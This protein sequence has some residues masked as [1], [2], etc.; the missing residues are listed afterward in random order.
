MSITLSQKLVTTCTAITGGIDP[1]DGIGEFYQFNLTGAA[2]IQTGDGYSIIVTDLTSGSQTLLGYGTV[3]GITPTFAFTFN[4]KEYVLAKDTVYFSSID[5][6]AS[7]NSL[8]GIGNSYVQLSD[9]NGQSTNLI[10]VAEFQGNLAFFSQNCIQIWQTNADPLQWDLVQTIQNSGTIAAN[11][12]QPMG[13]LDVLYLHY[14]GVRSLRA[15]EITGFSFVNDLGS[16]IDSLIQA[17]LIANGINSAAGACSIVDPTTGRYWLYL[18]GLIYIFSYFP[19]IKILSWSTYTP[20][21]FSPL[22]PATTGGSVVSFN[23]VPGHTYAWV[24][25]NATSVGEGG[26]NWY[27]SQNIVAPT[28]Q[29]YITYPGTPDESSTLTDLTQALTIVP[30]GFEIYNGQVYINTANGIY[31]YGGANN[32]TYDATQATA[33][34]AFLDF[35]HPGT[36]KAAESL[37]CDVSGGWNLYVGMVGPGQPMQ[38]GQL[39]DVMQLVF[40]TNIPSYQLQS[41]VCTNMEGYQVR[42]MAQTTGSTAAVLGALTFHYRMENEKD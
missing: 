25:G 36:L 20:T 40:T 41:Q 2:T 24:K 5:D 28:F 15:R 37:D 31:I 1:L 21:I 35:K 32:N 16:A 26:V 29:L 12:V 3:T 17:S 33:A 39:N 30:T 13:D 11:S 14:T 6:A 4:K 42:F 27:T 22:T 8:T 9:V 18:N 38:T 19:T 23:T 7:W 34:T 10:A